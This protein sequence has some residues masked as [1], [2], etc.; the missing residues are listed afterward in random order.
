MFSFLKVISRWIGRFFALLGLLFTNPNIFFRT[1]VPSLKKISSN[2]LTIWVKIK[3]VKKLYSA[4]KLLF[5]LQALLGTTIV[6][7]KVNPV[8]E[9]FQ[10]IYNLIILYSDNPVVNFFLSSYYA[11]LNFI[12]RTLDYAS[13]FIRGGIPKELEVKSKIEDRPAYRERVKDHYLEQKKEY[14]SLRAT[15]KVSPRPEKTWWSRFDFVS[16]LETRDYVMVGIIVVATGLLVYTNWDAITHFIASHTPGR[17]SDP[18]QG[19]GASSSSGPSTPPSGSKMDYFFKNVTGQDELRNQPSDS[20]SPQLSEIQ[21]GKQPQG[22]TQVA[23]DTSPIPSSSPATSGTTTP[24]A[25]GSTSS[26]STSPPIISSDEAARLAATMSADVLKAKDDLVDLYVNLGVRDSIVDADLDVQAYHM[27][28]ALDN[29]ELWTKFI[30]IDNVL[31]HSIYRT[32][33]AGI[34]DIPIPSW[35]ESNH[36]SEIVEVIVKINDEHIHSFS[37]LTEI[38]VKAKSTDPEL[39]RAIIKVPQ[40]YYEQDFKTK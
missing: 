25:G 35:H 1:W 34:L 26:S 14:E 24:T 22:Y 33:Q 17:G 20:G 19:G 2:L 9:F 32:V 4:I 29:G 40:I 10:Q 11:V 18:S 31:S 8:I 28:K 38:L 7:L 37:P 21:I 3:S 5:Y 23:G 6:V 15:Y 30:G 39:V 36:V 13:D 27:L 12:R 16:D